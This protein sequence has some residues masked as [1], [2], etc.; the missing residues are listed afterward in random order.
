MSCLLGHTGQ[1]FQEHCYFELVNVEE[2]HYN[3]SVMLIL[4][5]WN[6]LYRLASFLPCQCLWAY[7][8]EHYALEVEI[9]FTQYFFMVYIGVTNMEVY[10][11]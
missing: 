1:L 5:I 10:R 4:N 7:M 8:I 6:L 9:F 11:K 2:E 3:K